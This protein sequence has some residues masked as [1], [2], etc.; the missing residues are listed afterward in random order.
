MNDEPIRTREEW[1][2]VLA[3]A[4]GLILGVAEDI[5]ADY[6]RRQRKDRYRQIAE[7]QR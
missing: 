3:E 7:G 2:T 4:L 6:S 5:D 1:R